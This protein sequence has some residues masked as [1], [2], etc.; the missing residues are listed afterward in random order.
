MF[1]AICGRWFHSEI[2]TNLN[3][4]LKNSITIEVT[5]A[6]K[7][8]IHIGRIIK[9]N[10]FIAINNGKIIFN[11]KTQGEI[12]FNIAQYFEENNVEYS[13][14]ITGKGSKSVNKLTSKI[15]A[16]DIDFDILKGDQEIYS[17]IIGGEK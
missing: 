10:D 8:S 15:E 2:K 1:D 14:I 5:K 17:F 12:F 16:K 6:I 9:K 11:T 4:V 7:N 13:Y 3:E